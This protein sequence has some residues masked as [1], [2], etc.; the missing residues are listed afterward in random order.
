MDQQKFS[1]D[2][3]SNLP[4][5]P[6]VYKFFNKNDKIIYVGKAKNL[7]KRVSS[8]FQETAKHNRKTWKLSKEIGHIEI[9]IVNSEFDALLLE[10]SLIKENQPKYNILL[11]DDKTFPSILIT[12]ERFPKIYST[13]RIIKDKGQYFGP[14]TSVKAMNSVLDIIRKIYK[15]RT[16]SLLLSEKNIREHKFKVCL[17]Y[18]IGNC[19]GPC[20][21][22]QNETSYLDDI[23]SAKDI[24]KGNIQSLKSKYRHQM[25][26]ASSSLNFELAHQIKGKIDLLEHF[27]NKSLVVNP[28]INNIDVFGVVVS[29]SNVFIN[30]MKIQHGAI[31]VSETVEAKIKIEEELDDSLQTILFNLRIKYDSISTEILSNHE[32]GDWGD[33]EIIHPKIGD[34]KKLLNLSLKNAIYFKNDKALKKDA[35]DKTNVVVN[36]LQSDLSL[37]NPPLHIECFDNSNI[38]GSNPVASMVCFRNGKPSKKDY[39]KYNIKTVVGPDDFAS[40]KEVVGRRYKR[41]LEEEQSLP[42]LIVIDGGKGQLHSACDALKELSVYGQIPII[43]IA[44]RLEEIYYPEDQYPIHISKKSP[45]LKLLQHLR[46]EAH[47]FAINFHRNQRSKNSSVSELDSIKGIGKH[48]KDLLLQK[49]KSVKRLKSCASS[50]LEPLIGKHKSTIVIE[51]FLNKKGA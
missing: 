4:H 15:I 51:H 38:Q 45:S 46:D 19:L 5:L 49:F 43:G 17:E 34:K 44:K 26:E 20:V 41:L 42:D 30:Y 2:Q 48:T 31:R 50:D 21:G 24:L 10:N 18:H 3:H 9:V 37:K 11:K 27:Q 7:V 28:D 29:E 36:I 8:Y 35:E 23:E 33:W 16:C 13:R 6:G 12:N 1:V 47:R 32:L 22:L 39:R 25:N 14:Y 40:M